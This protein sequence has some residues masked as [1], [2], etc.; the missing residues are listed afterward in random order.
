MLAL[1]ARW[2]AMGGTAGLGCRT[3]RAYPRGFF[4]LKGG[5]GRLRKLEGLRA[6]RVVGR[7]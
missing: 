4:L 7:R 1:A 5:K 2:V 3:G 6:E